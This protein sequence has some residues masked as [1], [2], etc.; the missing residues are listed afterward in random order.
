MAPKIWDP[1]GPMLYPYRV[2]DRASYC[3]YVRD[4]GVRGGTFA[5][6]VLW[7]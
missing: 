7:R 5:V 2:R 1:G 3:N 6:Y 4:F